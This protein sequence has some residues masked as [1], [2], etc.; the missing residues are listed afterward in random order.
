[1][2]FSIKIDF[3]FLIDFTKLRYQLLVY[4][5]KCKVNIGNLRVMNI[6]LIRYYNYEKVI[7]IALK[8]KKYNYFIIFFFSNVTMIW[9][10][11]SIQ[12]TFTAKYPK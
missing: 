4:Y 6:I 5:H 9:N 2:K 1:M 11:G 10:I 3:G 7:K 8:I 12:L